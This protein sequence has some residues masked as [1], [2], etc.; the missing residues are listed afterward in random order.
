MHSP[1]IKILST[2]PFSKIYTTKY[3]H[4]VHMHTVLIILYVDK[5][6]EY[7]GGAMNER[8]KGCMAGYELMTT[9]INVRVHMTARACSIYVERMCMAEAFN[10]FAAHGPI[11]QDIY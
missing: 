6:W 7:V 8:V 2:S 9:N 3:I 4:T 1:Q 5:E 11:P 10:L